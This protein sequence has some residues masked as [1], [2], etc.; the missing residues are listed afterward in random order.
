MQ[1]KGGNWPK[2][3]Q[4]HVEEEKRGRRAVK[5]EAERQVTPLARLVVY[6][7]R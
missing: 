7:H 3:R 4:S 2:N 6:V 5:E 1:A